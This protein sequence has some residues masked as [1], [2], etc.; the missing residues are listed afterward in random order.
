M[1]SVF[2]GNAMC[3]FADVA[4]GDARGNAAAQFGTDALMFRDRDSTVKPLTRAIAETR[5]RGEDWLVC[6]NLGP[7]AGPV[8]ASAGADNGDR[9]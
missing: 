7:A 9:A 8:G 6:G 2:D 1:V 3:V 4:R 5:Q